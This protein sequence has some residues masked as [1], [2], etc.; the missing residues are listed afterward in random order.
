MKRFWGGVVV[1]AAVATVGVL[2]VSAEGPSPKA[3]SPLGSNVSIRVFQ[4][5]PGQLEVKKGTAVTWTN[6]DDIEHTVTSGTPERAD[7][8]F[9]L[10]LSGKTATSRFTFTEAGNYRYFC[11]RHQSMRGEIRVN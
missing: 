9:N 7:G 2:A 1:L 5:Q 6:Q 8:R 4:F 3:E 10:V 11:N